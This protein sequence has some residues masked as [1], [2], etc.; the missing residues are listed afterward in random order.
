[1]LQK[2]GSIPIEL[3]EPVGDRIY[4]CDD[5]Q[6]A[7]PPTVRFGPTN[8]APEQMATKAWMPVIA[9]LRS[10]DEEL[11]A[12]WSPWYLADRDPRWIRRNALVVLGN[13]GD[14]T[15][16]A[17]QAVVREY[18]AHPDSLLREHAEW[19]ARRLGLHAVSS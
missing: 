12:Q 2:P 5:C 7:C 1:M 8:R 3:R 6:E 13:I 9:L 15:D 16:V 4:G 17:V 10:T 11:L 19:C 18:V 14:A